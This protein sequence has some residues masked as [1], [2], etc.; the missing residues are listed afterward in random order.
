MDSV[1][2]DND[3]EFADVISS[4]YVHLMSHTRGLERLIIP[5][6]SGSVA[7]DALER[8]FA[9]KGGVVAAKAEGRGGFQGG[10]RFVLDCLTAQFKKESQEEQVNAVLK[11]A[12]GSLDY[13]RREGFMRALLDR[14]GPHLSPDIDISTPG[15]F[16]PQCEP[17]V[18]EYVASLERINQLLRAM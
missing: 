2:V 1:T 10:M 18:R 5:E 16:L 9:G 17:I 4:F 11:G 3:E 6:R 15:R 12:L 13:E 14:L 7:L 8:A